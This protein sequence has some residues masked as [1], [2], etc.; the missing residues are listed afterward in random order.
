[1]IANSEEIHVILH[2]DVSVDAKLIGVDEKTDIAVL[3]IDPEGHDL[4]AVPFG[5]S[6]VMRIGDWVLAIG[7]PFRSESV[8]RERV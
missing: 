1:M 5:D 7:N 8:C 6:A 3:Q 2:D 4:K